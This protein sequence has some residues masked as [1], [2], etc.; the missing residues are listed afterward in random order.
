MYGSDISEIA[1]ENAR[2]RYPVCSFF[3][4]T[5]S[6]LTHKK[7][8][9][10]FT[11]HVLE[12]VYNLPL[13]LDEINSYLKNKAAIFNILPCGNEGSFEHGLCLLRKDGINQQLENRFFFEDEGHVRRLTT[14]QLGKLYEAQGYVLASEY[15][16][17]QYHGA[18]EW[19][20]M[21]GPSFIRALT[22]T[23]QA[24]SETARKRLTGLRYKLMGIWALRV[25]AVLVENKV[26]KKNKKASDYFYLACGLPLYIF[27]K[28]VDWY[29]KKQ[30]WK[31][32]KTQ[33]S[34]RSGS[35]MYLFFKKT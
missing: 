32:W 9:F 3:V 22:D 8:D 14:A 27:S 4:A 24:V 18:I 10:I 15:Y 35:E 16:S 7:F 34:V 2:I 12:H 11:H 30:A 19:L 28:P 26:S 20:S 5:D 21:S 29:M 25:A 23:S 6:E 1:V 31:E 33:K 17:H 13:V